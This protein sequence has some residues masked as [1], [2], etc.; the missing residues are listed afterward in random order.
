MRP[1]PGTLLLLL[2]C[3]ACALLAAGPTQGFQPAV[4]GGRNALVDRYPWFASVMVASMPEAPHADKTP[5]CGG[6]LIAPDVVLTAAHCTAGPI[7]HVVL[8]KTH[9]RDDRGGEV[10]KV[11]AIVAG[12]LTPAFENDFAVL[13]LDTPT[14][15]APVKL[16]AS[17]APP[18]T[19][20]VI[21]FGMS[22]KLTPTPSIVV[23]PLSLYP[24]RLQEAPIPLRRGCESGM[25]CAG[26]VGTEGCSGDSGGP[27]FERGRT[28][29]DDV[30]HGITSFNI[31]GCGVGI[32]TVFASVFAYRLQIKDALAELARYRGNP[33]L[34]AREW[35]RNVDDA[36][37]AYLASRPKLS[38]AP[39]ALREHVLRELVRRRYVIPGINMKGVVSFFADAWCAQ[40]NM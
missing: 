25:F 3:L 32:P 8:G 16:A 37:A 22:K 9:L 28:A 34:R 39:A 23:D 33:Q 5:S 7:T 19:P 21:G 24:N 1:A 6:F 35:R 4:Y 13:L 17:A 12:K 10:R 11:V 20:W 26:G 15:R 38:C 30:V 18:A 29:A 14:R 31:G 40:K 2:T 27:L 36:V